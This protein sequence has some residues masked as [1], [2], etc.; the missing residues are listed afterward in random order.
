MKEY[1][2]MHPKRNNA[3]FKDEMQR[4]F[5]K[6]TDLMQKKMFF[7]ASWNAGVP[8]VM[9]QQADAPNSIVN[10]CHKFYCGSFWPNSANKHKMWRLIFIIWLPTSKSYY[11]YHGGTNFGRIVG[12][13]YITTSCD[14]DTT[15][16]EFGNLNQPKRG[17][18]KGL[19]TV[20]K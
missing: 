15:L 13:P 17:H 14:Y 18:L 19:R 7:L 20:L 5:K 10:A 16:D 11:M 8:W 4:F 2:R 12:G 6:I 9:C 1:A 3:P